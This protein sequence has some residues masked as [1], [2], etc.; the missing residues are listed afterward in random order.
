MFYFFVFEYNLSGNIA[1]SVL[2]FSE[3]HFFGGMCLLGKHPLE[4]K[5]GG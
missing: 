3:H 5:K 1:V 4:K 2:N